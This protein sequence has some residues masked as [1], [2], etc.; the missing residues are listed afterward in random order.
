MGTWAAEAPRCSRIV[1]PAPGG[2]AVD[3]HVRPPV[4]RRPRALP[5]NLRVADRADPAG[6][7]RRERADGRDR[8]FAGLGIPAQTIR[9]VTT[10]LP[11]CPAG[12][13][14]SGGALMTF[15]MTESSPGAA[16][17]AAA[18]PAI[19]SALAGSIGIPPAASPASWSRNRSLAATPK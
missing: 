5:V 12:T 17:A 13:N 19:T 11:C 1:S 6:E 15:A 18:G 16:S 4:E 10:G 3:E 8:L 9:A 7:R 14:G 2:Q